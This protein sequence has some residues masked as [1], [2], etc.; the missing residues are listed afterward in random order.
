LDNP[1]TAEIGMRALSYPLRPQQDIDGVDMYEAAAECS[2]HV[3]ID[4]SDYIPGIGGGR[5]DDIDG[6]AET[7]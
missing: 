6:D 1:T 7:A 4:L 3:P 2:G 5:F